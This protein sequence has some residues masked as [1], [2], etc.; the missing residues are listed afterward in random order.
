MSTPVVFR[1][2]NRNTAGRFPV[3]CVISRS[4]S[5]LPTVI[6]GDL[7]DL[8]SLEQSWQ[9][10]HDTYRE[11]LFQ[12][13]QTLPVRAVFDDLP[14]EPSLPSDVGELAQALQD[15]FG[16][17]ASDTGAH[18]LELQ[19][20]GIVGEQP[21]H[22]LLEAEDPSLQKLPWQLWRLISQRSAGALSLR[23]TNAHSVSKD[24][25]ISVKSPIKILAVIGDSEGI[26]TQAD[27]SIL[28]SLKGVVVEEPPGDPNT[29]MLERLVNALNTGEYDV[30]FY[31]GHSFSRQFRVNSGNFPN[32]SIS[33][34]AAPLRN[35]VARRLKLAIFNS[36][37]S[38][39]LARDLLN[40]GVPYVIA[41]RAPIPDPVAHKFLRRFGELFFTRG[42]ALHV[43]VRKASEDLLGIENECPCASLL[44]VLHQS[45]AAL[46]TMQIFTKK[47]TP[48]WPFYLGGSLLTLALVAAGVKFLETR[49]E[50]SIDVY[51]S[52]YLSYGEE[53]IIA[54]N[55]PLQATNDE[56]LSF[57]EA[58]SGKSDCQTQF[59]N[60]F[61][62]NSGSA[63]DDPTQCY[64]GLLSAWK[65]DP[66]TLVF[67]NNSLL[68]DK[69]LEDGNVKVYTVAVPLQVE[70]GSIRNSSLEIL[71]G[72]AQAQEEMNR[73]IDTQKWGLRV[74]IARE[75]GGTR[76]LAQALTMIPDVIGIIGHFTSEGMGDASPIYKDAGI[77]HITATATDDNLANAN[78]PY[79][80]RVVPNNTELAQRMLRY[81]SSKRSRVGQRLVEQ[82]VAT[83]ITDK[84]SYSQNLGTVF[85]KEFRFNGGKVVP[86]ITPFP[87]NG[88]ST[89]D[90]SPEVNQALRS[91]ANIFVLLPNSDNR[92]NALDAVA[93]ISEASQSQRKDTLVLGGDSLF[94]DDPLNKRSDGLAV[95]S[96][97]NC[98]QE[99]NRSVCNQARTLWGA[100]TNAWRTGLAYKATQTFGNAFTELSK[101]AQNTEDPN[102]LRTQVNRLLKP[103]FDSNGNARIRETDI[104]M[105]VV[106]CSPQS[107]TWI[108]SLD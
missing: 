81:I 99:Q 75:D 1:I 11:V 73:N 90:L 29:S 103:N 50:P 35:A 82:K 27:L 32:I 89:Y 62:N 85:N 30:L 43:A 98:F 4:G 36:C 84:D 58:M 79:F 60:K 86:E 104:D 59:L 51:A 77:P 87:E 45:S 26:N 31:A 47:Q 105:L 46:P 106:Q 9:M 10:L 38:Q 71:R 95:V 55:L 20:Q 42:E 93:A 100:E 101:T 48:R 39:G 102:D 94:G 64:E 83:F 40:I 41:M 69:K 23:N 65:N 70:S 61:K 63:A 52:N 72:V 80:Y 8:S 21:V 19:I 56:R 7:P 49:S 14:A 15:A 88:E 53:S 18:N 44:P 91:G 33:G 66:E 25:S 68:L 78:N 108:P 12:M 107:C 34:L 28:R 74:V 96:P 16:V 17:L 97:W 57:N 3:T 5:D 2:G 54:P 22:L 6:T 92:G 37:D 76:D 24:A 13:R 67:K